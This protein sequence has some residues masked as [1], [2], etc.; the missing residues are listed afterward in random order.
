V[1][2][3]DG[4]RPGASPVRG[5][6]PPLLVYTVLAVLATWP[7][8]G[9]LA[10]G[11]PHDLA[12]P[13]LNTWILWWNA[14]VVPFSGEWWS[15]PMFHPIPGALSFSESLVGLAPLTSTLQ[16]LGGPPLGAY[17]V[18]FILSFAFSA[19]AMYLLARAL[20]LGR[21]PGFAA[22]LA[23]GF[24]PQRAAHLAH[25]QVLA[26]YLVPIV[27]LAAHRYARTGQ[28]IWLWLL[29]A[30]VVTQGLTNGYFL[31]YVSVL[32]A[33]WL[34]WFAP[35]MTARRRAAWLLLA[36]VLAVAVLAPVLWTY[37]RW[38][39][40][41]GLA[42]KVEEIEAFSVDV[43]GVFAPAP[44]LAFWPSPPSLRPASC[45]F[46]GLTVALLL[47]LLV[48]EWVRARPRAQGRVAFGFAFVASAAALVAAGSAMAGPC[49]LP[50]GPVVVSVRALDK[51]LAIAFY[52]LILTL[53]STRSLRDAWRRGSIPAFYGI[54]AAAMIAFSFG[55]SPAAGDL[56]VWR[57][58]PYYFLLKLPG[59]SELRAP[60]RFAVLGVFCIA[61]TAAASLA[62]IA[63]RRRARHAT[64]IVAIAAAGTLADGWLARLPI[65]DAPPL[66]TLPEEAADAAVLELPVGTEEDTAAMFRGIE[67]GHTVVNGYSGYPPPHYLALRSGLLRGET[68]VLDALREQGPLLVLVDTSSKDAGALRRVAEAG[69]GVRPLGDRQGRTAY[70]MTREAPRP[71]PLLG[72]R[73]RTRLV[74]ASPRRAVFALE[75]PGLLGGVLL[76]FGA[77]VSTLPAAIA[78]ETGRPESWTMRWRG[79]V[80][81]RALRG[82]LRD[83][84]RVPVLIETPGASGPL[85]RI[86]VD[87]VWSIEEVVA[88]APR[89]HPGRLR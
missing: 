71:E 54:A 20:G 34:A 32:F 74:R 51:P 76:H 62:R 80:A 77:G 82:A 58:A 64:A 40:Q 43:R 35:S 17:N 86:R 47:L 16:W 59:F 53:L 56:H 13:L 68:D 81:G 46:P 5:L 73:V 61:L 42:R 27:F 44:G 78:V 19:A 9:R 57:K 72:A 29:A 75:P 79:P 11:V 89:A 3:R 66:L 21:G 48:A 7:L 69:T 33:G 49:R 30:T 12:D 38:H 52:A 15:G 41:Y 31:A 88:L 10:T 70:L 39:A 60:Q 22:G 26:T 50:L 23:F 84:R 4:G 87:G 67:H 18:A 55:P 37:S 85:L 8:A 14:H 6:F 36:W 2:E 25:I 24:A 1:P 83:P 65:R 28:R 63:G 45:L